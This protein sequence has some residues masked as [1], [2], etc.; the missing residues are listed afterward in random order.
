MRII[1]LLCLS[2]IWLLAQERENRN[3]PIFEPIPYFE[4]NDSIEGW[5][6]SADGQWLSSAQAIPKIGISRNTGFYKNEANALGID[7]ISTLKAYKIKYGPDTLICLVK[8]YNDGRYKFP[9]R[10][11]GWR[12]FKNA[13]F[14][15][16]YYKHLEKALDYYESTDTSE[17][18][19]L[20]I[21]SIDGRL[22]EDI[23]ED[24]LLKN[25]IASTIVKPNFDRNLVLTLQEGDKPDRLRFHICSLHAIF[26]D[27]EGIRNNFTK[28]G[29]SVYGSTKLF[30]YLYFEMDKKEFFSILNLDGNL[31]QLLEAEMLPV[32]DQAR[33]GEESSLDSLDL[34]LD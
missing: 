20:K 3:L 8:V 28:G 33:D 9:N 7:N 16:F 13:Y 18:T 22:L 26:S 11:K 34:N 12:E 4:V 15:I 25:I 17:A 27:V 2:P 5:S 10:K 19:V 14:W 24:D 29:R 21:K 31:D 1:F 32:F 30:D 6:F 23:D